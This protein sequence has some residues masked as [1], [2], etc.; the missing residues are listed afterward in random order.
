MPTARE[1]L[2][3]EGDIVRLAAPIVT[4]A[5]KFRIGDGEATLFH[6]EGSDITELTLVKILEL[7]EDGNQPMRIELFGEIDDSYSTL[8]NRKGT[9]EYEIRTN[10]YGTCSVIQPNL[11][12]FRIWLHEKKWKDFNLAKNQKRVSRVLDDIARTPNL[13]SQPW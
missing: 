2:L 5:E 4:R 6:T 8:I 12:L 9:I 11:N 10:I 1:L 13:S 3:K 7:T